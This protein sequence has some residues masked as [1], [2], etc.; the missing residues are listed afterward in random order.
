MK[1][2]DKRLFL[3]LVISL[4]MLLTNFFVLKINSLIFHLIFVIALFIIIKINVGFERER[5]FDRKK[6]IILSLFYTIAFLI[7]KYSIGLITGYLTNPYNFSIIYK[8]VIPYFIII[9]FSELIRY[10]I[11][12]KS[13]SK[14]VFIFNILLFT[15]IDIVC[16][17]NTVV[18][19]D[20][21]SII[22]FVATG[23]NICLFKS[24]GL[25]LISKK[26]GYIS[27]LIYAIIF[28]I[29][30]YL[31]PI[32]PDLGDYVNTVYQMLIPIFIYI[33]LNI[34]LTKYK[35]EDVRAKNVI[36]ASIRFIIIVLILIMVSL[37]S[38][39][40]RYWVAV[41]GSGSMSPTIDMGDII[42]VDKSYKEKIDELKEGDILVFKIEN[43][44]YTHR[45]INIDNT[46]GDIYITTKGDREGQAVD[47]WKVKKEN[48]IGKTK[49]RF[50]KIGL[51]AIYLKE[52][53]E[54]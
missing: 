32:I 50:R 30:E 5:L 29:Y 10:T 3:I 34:A 37:N 53:M 27:T 48:I 9:L 11:N 1:N 6:I 25:T 8:I 14:L 35:L 15:M 36:L 2:V 40:F 31:L 28:G 17:Y 43:T 41:V 7:I 52:L 47:N 38:N 33:F 20:I 4:A 42:L 13:D 12:N 44:I 19:S 18:I 16:L 24:I 51:P 49:M 39:L 45:I 21:S 26:Y 46:T 54:G 22:I 23:F